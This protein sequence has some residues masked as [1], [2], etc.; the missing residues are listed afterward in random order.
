[1]KSISR[2]AF[3]E[4]LVAFFKIKPPGSRAEFHMESQGGLYLP[5]FKGSIQI[6]FGSRIGQIP[7]TLDCSSSPPPYVIEH[8]YTAA[9]SYFPSG[10]SAE[11]IEARKALMEKYNIRPYLISDEDA[12]TKPAKEV[13]KVFTFLG[14]NLKHGMTRSDFDC[15]TKAVFEEIRH[16]NERPYKSV[17]THDPNNWTR[18]YTPHPDDIGSSCLAYS[19]GLLYL[20]SFWKKELS[21]V[22]VTDVELVAQN[23]LERDPLPPLDLTAPPRSFHDAI[24]LLGLEHFIEKNGTD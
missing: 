11:E 24:H 13:K 1:M 4:T 15:E 7:V 10:F 12:F 16:G 20:F 22:N 9:K 8:N 21:G 17:Y 18:G 5:K 14:L 6:E 2:Q 3:R 19:D 23:D